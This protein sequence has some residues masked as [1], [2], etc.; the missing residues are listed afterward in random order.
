M[1][2][3]DW[4]SEPNCE[5]SCSIAKQIF[6]Y[7]MDG[8]YETLK[9]CE[10][11]K[12]NL[13]GYCQGATYGLIALYYYPEL[14]RR[15]VFYNIPVDFTIAGL[16]QP[17]Q[18]LSP[19]LIDSIPL[20]NLPFQLTD[21]PTYLGD[22][23]LSNQNL[24]LTRGT[25]F[26]VPMENSYKWLRAVNKWENDAVPMPKNIFSEW[27]RLFYQENRLANNILSLD[28]K[29]IILEDIETPILS[30]VAEID[31]IAPKVMALPIK[32]RLPNGKEL[33]IPGG[34]LSTTAGQFAIKHAWPATVN[35]FRNNKELLSNI[36]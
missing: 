15:A 24:N 18:L 12:I 7:M 9:A 4:I 8:V 6:S 20:N 35:W 23:F 32:N 36:S 26:R 25:L 28:G 3:L 5:G 16:F 33:C 2:L 31:D 17:S 22:Y 11:D 1:F 29:K 21:I 14:F 27:V 13:A 34:H 19:F 30:I 10:V